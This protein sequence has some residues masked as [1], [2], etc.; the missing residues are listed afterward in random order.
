MAVNFRMSMGD[1]ST[2]SLGERQLCGKGFLI[3]IYCTTCDTHPSY[4]WS[5][6]AKDADDWTLI[7][8]ED[9]GTYEQVMDHV[10]YRGFL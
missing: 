9:F 8:Y 2:H 4:Y 3:D 10:K 7:D 1:W 6:Y 5:V